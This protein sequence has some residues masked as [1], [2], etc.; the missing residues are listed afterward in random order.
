[1][2]PV[3]SPQAG[4][5]LRAADRFVAG[6]GGPTLLCI[7]P[8]SQPIPRAVAL[9][10]SDYRNVGHSDTGEALVQSLDV[11]ASRNAATNRASGCWRTTVST[12][13]TRARSRSVST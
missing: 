6:S 12:T 2:Q 8:P 3:V 13:R 10:S 7:P 9:Q 5:D 1:M 4:D 11:N